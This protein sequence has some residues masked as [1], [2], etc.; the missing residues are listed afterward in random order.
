MNNFKV[1]IIGMGPMGFRHLESYSGLDG[2]EVVCVCDSREEI[3]EKVPGVKFYN[4][5][6][7]MIEKENFDVVSVVTNGPS[8]AEIVVSCAEKKI[9]HILCE[10]PMAT[11]VLDAKK[12]IKACEENNVRFAINHTRARGYPTSIKLA[13]LLKEGIIGDVRHIHCVDGGGR[14]GAVGIHHFDLM[15]MY[16]GS[17]AD[18]VVGFLD[19]NYKGDHKSRDVFDPGAY[20][21]VHFKNG[22]RGTLELCEDIGCPEFIVIT[23]SVGRVIIRNEDNYCKILVRSN[24]DKKKKLG[25]YDLPLYE[26]PFESKEFDIIESTKYLIKNLC[27]SE[28]IISSAKDGLA[29]LEIALAFHISDKNGN[30]KIG[31]PYEDENFNVDMT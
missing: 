7:E 24:E 9:P 10:K 21:I 20:G 22:A 6:K 27:S 28:E 25:E 2:F 15:R 17:E 13:K 4:N 5:Y 23:G 30:K 1:G 26:F 16:S 8:H 3:K 12:M 18:W 31:L 19:E 14:L 29:A 11:S